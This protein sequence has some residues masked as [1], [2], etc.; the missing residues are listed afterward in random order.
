MLFSPLLLPLLL[1]KSWWDLNALHTVAI[2]NFPP[3]QGI[4][5]PWL[6]CLTSYNEESAVSFSL[7]LVSTRVGT[8]QGDCNQ[9]LV[10]ET[11]DTELLMKFAAHSWTVRGVS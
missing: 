9:N 7:G 1:S 11:E 4:C 8:W 5:T 3:K 10:M 6:T 2:L